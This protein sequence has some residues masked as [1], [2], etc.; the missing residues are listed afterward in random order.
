MCW[1]SGGQ[2][3]DG[4]VDDDG[5]QDEDGVADDDGGQDEDGVAGDDGGQED[6]VES[7]PRTLLL[8]H[9]VLL[10]LSSA[11]YVCCSERVDEICPCSGLCVGSTLVLSTG[12]G[13]KT[14]VK[15][16]ILNFFII[17][18]FLDVVVVDVTVV[19]VEVDG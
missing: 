12:V 13:S 16:V 10:V 6:P 18:V 15:F 1:L 11:S 5:G 19:V 2:D 3:E 7:R 14:P 8:S 4:V 17:P 9:L